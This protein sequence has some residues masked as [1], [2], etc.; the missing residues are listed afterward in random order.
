[1]IYLHQ[2]T[3]ESDLTISPGFY[4]HVKFREN[5]TVAKISEFTVWVPC[6][7]KCCVVTNLS[8]NLVVTKFY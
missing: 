3:T 2:E 4:F 7:L 6:I 8:Y 1:M 5:K